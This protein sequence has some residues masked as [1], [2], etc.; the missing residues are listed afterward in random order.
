MKFYKLTE[1][2]LALELVDPKVTEVPFP[3]LTTPLC[4]ARKSLK[5]YF[6]HP[7]TLGSLELL[8]SKPKIPHDSTQYLHTSNAD[9]N[10]AN[11][12]QMFLNEVF[13]LGNAT[14]LQGKREETG[15]VTFI[16]TS[17]VSL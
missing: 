9:P 3:Y 5:Y 4:Q 7:L 11:N 2:A 8:P 10:Y 14:I 16:L 13:Q 15:K 17:C 12:F 6:F 1:K